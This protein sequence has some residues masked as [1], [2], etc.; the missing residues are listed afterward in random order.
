MGGGVGHSRHVLLG[1]QK[2]FPG[3]YH[4]IWA[5][6]ILFGQLAYETACPKLSEVL[7]LVSRPLDLIETW[8]FREDIKDIKGIG[9]IMM[10]K[11]RTTTRWRATTRT[12]TTTRR[13]TITMVS[14]LWDTADIKRQFVLAFH[15]S[16]VLRYK[17]METVFYGCINDNNLLKKS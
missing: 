9:L 14:Q 2:I 4:H 15:I 5:H 7:N 3:I 13:T 10:M 8:G 16:F 11:W 1:I 6:Y 12:T 17:V